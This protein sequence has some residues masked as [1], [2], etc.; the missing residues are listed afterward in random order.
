MVFHLIGDG[1]AT[2]A[3]ISRQ[4]HHVA[5]SP[6]SATCPRGRR[7]VALPHHAL[8]SSHR[9]DMCRVCRRRWFVLRGCDAN[10]WQGLG[11]R[12]ASDEASKAANGIEAATKAEERKRTPASPSAADASPAAPAAPAPLAAH[13]HTQFIRSNTQTE[14]HTLWDKGPRG[15]RQWQRQTEAETESSVAVCAAAPRAANWAP[16]EVPGWCCH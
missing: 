10:G 3:V 11:R 14:R 6:D 5:P 4:C 7:R 1:L 8:V 15:G 16:R 13:P 2:C 9:L 12:G